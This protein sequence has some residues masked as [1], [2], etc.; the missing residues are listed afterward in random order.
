VDERTETNDKITVTAEF[1]TYFFEDFE[2]KKGADLLPTHRMDWKLKAV[3]GIG[4]NFFGGTKG[5]AFKDSDTD[6]K[7]D[8]SV[9]DGTPH[10]NAEKNDPGNEGWEASEGKYD[11]K[12]D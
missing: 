8:P 10:A 4:L 6:I 12:K 1:A 9:A 3:A 11:K 5:R 2:I 7:A